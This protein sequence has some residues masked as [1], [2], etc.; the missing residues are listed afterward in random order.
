MTIKEAINKEMQNIKDLQ[1]ILAKLEEAEKT[2]PAD[3]WN[4]FMDDI[5][6]ILAGQSLTMNQIQAEIDIAKKGNDDPIR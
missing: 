2:I 3:K 6:R 4:K 1:A 5:D